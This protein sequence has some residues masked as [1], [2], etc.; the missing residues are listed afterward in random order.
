MHNN[1]VSDEFGLLCYLHLS[2][3]IIRSAILA[4]TNSIDLMAVIAFGLGIYY[5]GIS[6]C[7]QLS[8]DKQSNF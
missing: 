8:V 3:D 1:W 4:T 7:P 2:S 6:L 5:S